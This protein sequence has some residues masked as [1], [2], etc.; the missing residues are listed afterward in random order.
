MGKTITRHWPK[1][2]PRGDFQQICS[3]C[4]VQWRNSQLVKDRSGLWACPDDV[5]G[6]DTVTLDEGNATYARQRHG[7]VYVREGGNFD[8]DGP[9]KDGSES[10]PLPPNTLQHR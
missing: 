1:K 9:A 8:D 2:A 7:T 4:G 6:R 3:Y 5:R 10:P